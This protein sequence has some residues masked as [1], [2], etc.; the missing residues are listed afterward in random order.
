MSASRYGGAAPAPKPFAYVP[1]ADGPLERRDPGVRQGHDQLT[2]G[3]LAG[4]LE[5]RLVALTPVHVGAGGV[6][7]TA[8]VAPALAAETPLLLPLVRAAGVPVLP[9]PTLKGA[10]R[11]VIEAIAPACL[12]LRGPTTRL[13]PPSLHALQ[14]CSRRYELCIAC[15]LFGALGYQ[16]RLRFADAPLSGG[17]TMVV[18]APPLH[19]PGGAR[20]RVPPGRRFYRH[21]QPARGTVPLEACPAGASFRWRLDFA[22]LLPAELGLLLVALGQG[23]PPLWLKLGGHK[24]ACLGSVRLE[25]ARLAVDDAAARY[26][27]YDAGDGAPSADSPDPAPYL[28]ALA[29]SGLLLADRLDRLAAILRYPGEGDCPAGGY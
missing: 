25:L 14:P 20:G 5:G 10:V 18:F 23:E 15:R 12:A 4:R 6:E 28:Q 17:E 16:G 7:R 29:E 21:G 26:L 9:G 2:P 27:A 1:L 11:S 24:P 22:N 19:A 13:L 3:L 8:R